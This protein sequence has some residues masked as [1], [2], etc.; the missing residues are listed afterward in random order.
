MY[1][2]CISYVISVGVSI[3]CQMSRSNCM[4]YRLWG[5]QESSY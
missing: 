3:S 1:V 5:V 4:L 2:T